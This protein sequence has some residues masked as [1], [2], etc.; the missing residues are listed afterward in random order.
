[1]LTNS[2]HIVVLSYRKFILI[3]NVLEFIEMGNKLKMEYIQTH[4]NRNSFN[5]F[6][7]S[8]HWLRIWRED[9]KWFEVL[10]SSENSFEIFFSLFF[11]FYFFFFFQFTSSFHFSSFIFIHSLNL[12]EF[13]SLVQ[14][15]W[16]RPQF[17]GFA[18]NEPLKSDPL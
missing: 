11:F 10:F 5:R 2:V 16:I 15:P 6:T 4:K 1:M 18:G 3:W 17:C 13:L 14:F 12:K 9:E 7:V 8:H